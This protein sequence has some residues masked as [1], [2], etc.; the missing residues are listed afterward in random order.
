MRCRSPGHAAGTHLRIPLDLQREGVGDAGD[1]DEGQAGA[2]FRD[3]H[4]RA[5][6]RRGAI[7]DVG[8]GRPVIAG[9]AGMLALFRCH[10]PR[11]EFVAIYLI[12]LIIYKNFGGE[13]GGNRGKY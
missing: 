11:L 8:H 6:D 13:F 12:L 3:I 10:F 2:A 9:L 7:P 4:Y 1:V 5:H